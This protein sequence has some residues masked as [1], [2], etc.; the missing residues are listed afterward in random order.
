[1][2]YTLAEIKAIVLADLHRVPTDTTFDATTLKN[3]INAGRQKAARLVY[4]MA[5]ADTVQQN[6]V[7]GTRDYILNASADGIGGFVSVS[8]RDEA[9]GT[10]RLLTP[11][12]LSQLAELTGYP[13]VDTGSC[14]P[15]CYVLRRPHANGVVISLYPT[16][17]ASIA[18]GLLAE[19]SQAVNA[20]AT[21]VSVSALPAAVDE[22][23]AHT[24]ALELSALIIDEEPT[25]AAL[26]L[27]NQLR[28]EALRAAKDD[29]YTFQDRPLKL[30]PGIKIGKQR[31]GKVTYTPIV[32]EFSSGGG[33]GGEMLIY[34]HDLA[35]S[36]NGS[37]IVTIP[38]TYR[39][40]TDADD[41]V[42]VFSEEQGFVK[43]Y[44]VDA[45]RRSV[46]AQARAGQQFYGEQ[47]VVYYQTDE[48]I[49]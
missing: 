1:M 37:D 3:R 43:A 8:V 25:R 14:P 49:V 21:D 28:S 36:T 41:S 22:L 34:T 12:A 16:P 20:L 4:G 19:V 17:S 6:L 48:E 47:V 44:S 35:A 26:P 18:N 31:K 7:D 9:A 29:Y 27:I 15:F 45:N 13:E 39:V 40:A 38:L 23:A 5:V 32:T 24:V 42:I 2:A 33:G 46:Q 10:P 30:K 11:V